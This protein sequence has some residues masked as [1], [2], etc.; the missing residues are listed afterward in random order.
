[1]PE[2]INILLVKRFN[3]KGNNDKT[4]HHLVGG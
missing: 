1:V 2:R 3:Y 4:W